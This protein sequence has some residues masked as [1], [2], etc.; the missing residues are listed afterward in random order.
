MQ[1]NRPQPLLPLA[2]LEPHLAMQSTA[3][4]Q[5]SLDAQATVDLLRHVIHRLKLVQKLRQQMGAADA[6]GSCRLASYCKGREALLL[7]RK[8]H[9]VVLLSCEATLPATLEAA[10]AAKPAPAALA[11]RHADSDVLCCTSFPCSGILEVAKAAK[12]LSEIAA[13]DAEADLGGIDAV[14][15]DAEFLQTAAAVVRSQTE[16]RRCRELWPGW[17]YRVLLATCN[18]LQQWAGRSGGT[19]LLCMVAACIHNHNPLSVPCRL[20]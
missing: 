8:L 13:V 14:D 1:P 16:V 20:L 17:S 18:C 9:I 4:C 3:A 6:A 19:R 10:K 15:A 7:F 2:C 5:H 11:K 12:L